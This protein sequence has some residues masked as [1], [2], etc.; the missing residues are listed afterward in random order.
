MRT[1][2]WG[3]R[4]CQYL[5][6]NLNCKTILPPLLGTRDLNYQIPSLQNNLVQQS[7]K[8]SQQCNKR[9]FH[10]FY[11]QHANIKVLYAIKMF[12][13]STIYILPENKVD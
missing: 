1:D 10:T 4:I 5:E 13:H 3:I 11:M 6:G 9:D 12:G 8:I 2:Q 7:G